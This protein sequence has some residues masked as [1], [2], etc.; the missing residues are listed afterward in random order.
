[1]ANG[2][3]FYRLKMTKG[4]GQGVRAATVTPVDRFTAGFEAGEASTPNLDILI[5]PNPFLNDGSQAIPPGLTKRDLV[6]TGDGSGSAVGFRLDFADGNGSGR[7]SFQ[8]IK[9][10]GLTL[11][12]PFECSSGSYY[13]P[14]APSGGSV[15]VTF[16]ANYTDAAASSMVVTML[17]LDGTVAHLKIDVG[18][19][20]QSFH[21]TVS[22]PFKASVEADADVMVNWD[23]EGVAVG[24]KPV[25]TVA[26]DSL[27]V[28]SDHV[29]QGGTMRVTA[30]GLGAYANAWGPTDAAGASEEATLHSVHMYS[31]IFIA[32]LDFTAGVPDYIIALN[33]GGAGGPTLAVDGTDVIWR[34]QDDSGDDMNIAH[35]S[36]SGWYAI[37]VAAERVQSS[38]G[39]I[40]MWLTRLTEGFTHGNVDSAAKASSVTSGGFGSGAKV[41]TYSNV[42]TNAGTSRLCAWAGFSTQKTE[43]Q[44]AEH[45]EEIAL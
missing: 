18:S 20:T 40:A 1:M 39:A 12:T 27:G 16:K 11:A 4:S 5:A 32:Y 22:N 34:K 45:V 42:S 23:A 21:A 24:S 41:R 10:D 9:V 19:P 25:G 3:P 44:L 26:E 2:P 43:A 17:S 35:D 37:S 13:P 29:R 28:E 31:M 33:L 38:G 36:T 7:A 8:I 14:T 30:D 6:I 15:T